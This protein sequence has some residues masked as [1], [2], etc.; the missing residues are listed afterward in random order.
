MNLLKLV[1]LGTAAV[2]EHNGCVTVVVD[3]IMSVCPSPICLV[4]GTSESALPQQ[5]ACCRNRLVSASVITY[6]DLAPRVQLA[7]Y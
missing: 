6:E 7:S 4:D 5:V 1:M 3:K 2:Q